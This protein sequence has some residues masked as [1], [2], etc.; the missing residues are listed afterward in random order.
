MTPSTLSALRRLHALRTLD[1]IDASEVVDWAAEQLVMSPD[2]ISVASLSRKASSED[3]DNETEGVL[4]GAGDPPMSTFRAGQLLALEVAAEIADGSSEPIVGARRLWALARRVPDIEPELRPF[5]GFASEW[6]DA[7]KFRSDY[8]ADIVA[9]ATRL[10][11]L[12]PIGSIR[13]SD[14]PSVD[15]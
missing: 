6:E 3:V 9:E 8:E 4:L 11:V 14:R 15:G 5:I 7:P 12:W 10:I 1:L 2:L 13:R